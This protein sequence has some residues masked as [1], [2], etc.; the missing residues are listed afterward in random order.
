MD[1]NE[2]N[3]N[4]IVANIALWLGVALPLLGGAELIGITDSLPSLIKTPFTAP[5]MIIVG[6]V[7]LVFS[8]KYFANQTKKNKNSIVEK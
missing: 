3:E 6:L 4:S 5:S 1:K 8:V 7:L 2:A